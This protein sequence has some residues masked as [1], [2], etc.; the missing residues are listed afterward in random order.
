MG[1]EAR[2]GRSEGVFVSNRALGLVFRADLGRI[3]RDSCRVASPCRT[4][5]IGNR[6]LHDP[7]GRHGTIAEISVDPVDQ[8]RRAVLDVEGDGRINLNLQ[9][10]SR[11]PG[12]PGLDLR[13]CLHAPRPF[14]LERTRVPRQFTP[15]DLRPVQ[16]QA[17]CGKAMLFKGF[18][19]DAGN[20]ARQCARAKTRSARLPDV[21]A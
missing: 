6:L 14:Q 19:R 11:P 9:G 1:T 5:R 13:E 10:G 8:L 20:Q 3:R 17:G 16:N 2:Q 12:L 18:L 21:I 4:G 15:D 7:Q